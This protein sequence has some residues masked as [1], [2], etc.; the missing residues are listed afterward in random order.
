M[1]PVLRFLDRLMPDPHP[2]FVFE[3]GGGGVVGARRDGSTV[4]KTAYR[5]LPDTT[6]DSAG[7]ALPEELATAIRDMLP[8]IGPHTSRMATLLLPDAAVRLAVFEFEK[9]PRRERDLRRAV[10]ERFAGS[11][12]FDVRAARIQHCRQ[13]GRSRES[14]LALATPERYVEHCEEAVRACGLVPA[15]VGSATAGVLSLVGG[16]GMELLLRLSGGAMTLAAVTGPS[17]TLLRRISLP[18]GLHPDAA[19]AT[20]DLLT[21]IVPTLAFAEGHV[22]GKIARVVLT[23]F[24]TLQRTLLETL[25]GHLGLPAVPLPIPG[26]ASAECGPGLAGYVHG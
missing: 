18:E 14:V 8:E 13:S 11:L 20:R 7:L 9:L 6:Q 16:K 12:P 22:G 23:G 5:E 10:A 1:G 15:F 21:D 4:R 3:I 17:V 26:D 2:A 24:G 19:A 25:P